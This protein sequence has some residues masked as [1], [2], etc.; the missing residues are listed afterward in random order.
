MDYIFGGNSIDDQID[1]YQIQCI[2]VHRNP[3][4]MIQGFGYVA[5][6]RSDG[7]TKIYGVLI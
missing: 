4:N 1:I 6:Y 2:D 5:N 7:N 3:E